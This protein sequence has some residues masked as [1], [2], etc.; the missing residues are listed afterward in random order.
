MDK[1][2]FSVREILAGEAP[3]D[4]PVTV[5][6]WVEGTVRQFFPEIEKVESIN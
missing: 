6:G 2:A 3:H 4:A 5:K 1:N